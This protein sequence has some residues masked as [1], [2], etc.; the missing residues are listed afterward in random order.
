MGLFEHARRRKPRREHGYC[1]DDVAR[2]LAAVVRAPASAP[3]P[4]LL[5]PIYL[6][7]LEQAQ[8]PDGRFHNRRSAGAG[9]RLTDRV[10]SDDSNGRALYGLGVAAACAAGGLATRALRCFE[11]GA[12]AFSSPSPRANAY[13]VLGAAAVASRDPGHSG[14]ALLLRRAEARLP[15]LSDGPGWRWPEHRLAYDNARLAEALIEAGQ[16][17]RRPQLVEQGLALLGWLVELERDG[18]HFSFA[19]AGGWAPGEPRP[20]FDQQPTEASAMAEA[21]AAAYAATGE[22]RYAE[23][24]VLAANWFF[25]LNDSGVELA[26]RRS[27]GCRDGLERE[28]ANE[29]QGAES[30]LAL[31]SALQAVGRV[32]AAVRSASSSSSTETYAAPTQRS[33]APYV[34]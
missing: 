7:Y 5:A 4:A 11:S 8:R 31:I 28:G 18:D 9:G 34:I 13:A 6:S 2:A 21:C 12:A 25:G 16:S 22:D 20:G 29:N 33:A 15:R 14:A 10:G 23:L 19:P 30:T 3:A 27:G 32:Q 24:V 1:S 17:F 26:D